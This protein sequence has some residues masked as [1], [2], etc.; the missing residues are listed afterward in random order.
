MAYYHQGAAYGYYS[1]L[2][3]FPHTRSAVVV[4]TNSIPLNDAADWIAQVYISTLFGNSYGSEYIALAEESRRRKVTN[5][6][7]MMSDFD[8]IRKNNPGG[9]RCANAYTGRFYNDAGNF[10]IDVREHP[11][12]DDILQLAFQG[13]DTQVYDLRHLCNDIFEWGL[14]YNES[15]RRARFAIWDPL[16]FQLDFTF[17]DSTTASSFTW[18]RDADMFPQG[19]TMTRLSERYL[20]SYLPQQKLGSWLLRPSHRWF[21]RDSNGQGHNFK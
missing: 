17:G 16:Y 19:F 14:E 13:K 12:S 5:V 2:F 8:K 10:F 3:V 9:M 6:E 4:L 21:G 15:A 7:A 11:R 20:N 18:A 1:T